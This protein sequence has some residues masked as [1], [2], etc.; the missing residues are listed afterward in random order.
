MYQSQISKLKWNRISDGTNK[1]VYVYLLHPIRTIIQLYLYE[2]QRDFNRVS[3]LKFET[4]VRLTTVL[5]RTVLSKYLFGEK[6]RQKDANPVKCSKILLAK[7]WTPI[8]PTKP[9]CLHVLNLSL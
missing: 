2:Y 9:I 8:L 3:I 4:R 6:Y 7:L 5:T 1:Q